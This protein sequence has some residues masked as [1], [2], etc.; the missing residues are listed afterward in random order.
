MKKINV[1][2]LFDGI[3]IGQLALQDADIQYDKYFASEIEPKAIKVTQDNFPDTI[4]L[5]DVLDW[6]K[7]DL[8]KIDILFAGFPCQA[9]SKAGK[10]KAFADPRGELA[11][12]LLEIF[13]TLKAKNPNL[14]FVFENT[15]MNPNVKKK[16]DEMFGVEGVVIDSALVSPQSRKRI[17]WTNLDYNFPEDQGITL[18]SVLSSGITD[19]EKSYC[20]RLCRGNPRDYF[21]KKHTQIVF[22]PN[23]EGK[24]EVKDKKISMSF[25]KSKAPEKI[26]V[27][28]VDIPDGRYNVRPLNRNECESLQTVK[29][30]YT[31]AVTEAQASDLLGNG[32]TVKIISNFLKALN[33]DK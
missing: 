25:P 5:G 22:E 4:Q 7:W 19:R 32:W 3:S 11:L 1:L 29:K 10:G 33:Y 8:P 9:F 16:L 12:V 18:Q 28:D 23:N 21:V 2:S 26:H 24:Y 13:E 15:E 14:K 20:L 6:K 30:D 27:F 17:Y 31:K